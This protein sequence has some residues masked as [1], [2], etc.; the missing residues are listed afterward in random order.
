MCPG[1]AIMD[2]RTVCRRFFARFRVNAN[3]NLLVDGYYFFVRKNAVFVSLDFACSSIGVNDYLQLFFIDSYITSSRYVT[4]AVLDM[5][6]LLFFIDYKAVRI[7]FDFLAYQLISLP[8][9]NVF[10]LAT[11]IIHRICFVCNI[12]VRL[13][14]RPFL[15]PSVTSR[16]HAVMLLAL[17]YT[18]LRR[19]GYSLLTVILSGQ[20]IGLI[21]KL[22]VKRR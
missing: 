17:S 5:S 10:G 9:F 14:R 6:D 22:P 8:C 4:A 21:Q 15:L 13:F 1:I 20:L 7:R 11:R 12:N 2:I 3:A 18:P 19:I 16:L